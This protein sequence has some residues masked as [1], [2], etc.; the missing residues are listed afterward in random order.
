MALELYNTLTRKR[1]R[2]EP[3]QKGRVGIYVCGPTVY[4]H[5]H[6]GHAKSYVSFDVLVRYLRYIGYS[7]TYVQ[8]ITDVGHLTDDADQGEDKV[9][10]AARREKKHPMAV[11]EYY[12]RSYFD[13]MDRLNCVRP[14]ISPRATGH[15]TEQ[16]EL[17]KTLLDKGYAYEV[18]GSVYFD[19]SKFSEYGKLSGRKVEEMLAGARVQVSEEKRNPV[20]FAL[21]K[22]A[23]PNHIMQWPS[24][25]GMGYPGWHL[26]CSVMS[27]KYLGKTIDI[28]GGGLE[29]QFPHHDCEI[30][31][32]EA[33]NGVQ[34]VRYWLHNNMVTVDGQKMGKSL[35]NFITL[36]QVFSG[37]HE[38]LMRAYEP[39]AVR[40]LVLNSHYRSPL[41]FSDAALYA[42]QSGYRKIND[43]VRSLRRAIAG[44]PAGDA[45]KDVSRQLDQLKQ[46]FEEAMDDDLNTS[47][48]LSVVFEVVRLTN[49]LLEQPAVTAGTLGEVEGWFDRLAGDVLGVVDKEQSSGADER[50]FESVMN[51]LIEQRNQARQRKDFA[52]AD[53]I[54]DRLSEA[55]IVLEDRPEGTRWRLK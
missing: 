23:E 42:A 40:Q 24:P 6:L 26:E 2:F 19:V 9:V 11:A 14:D 4:G 29:N 47:V 13:D 27:M 7:V 12:T 18:N 36:K 50:L 39:L 8:N 1:E 33:A 21:W 25:W 20:D 28:H 31:Q 55:G 41:D 38:R 5:A 37:S 48:A 34:F 3:L 15:I 45:D 32:S 30:A 16:I 10:A 17:V 44:A 54:R 49:A 46:R 43:T 51:I 22:K 35:N 52:A 53:A